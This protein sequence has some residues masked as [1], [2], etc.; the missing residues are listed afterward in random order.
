MIE[1]KLLHG[2]CL[3]EMRKMPDGGGGC[4]VYISTIQ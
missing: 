2:D 1:Y 4:D 3:E